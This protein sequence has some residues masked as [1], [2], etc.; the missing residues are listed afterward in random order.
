MTTIINNID[1][2][3]NLTDLDNTKNNYEK[4]LQDYNIKIQTKENE[5]TNLEK[6]VTIQQ[7][8]YWDVKN[9]SSY[10]KIAQAQ[11]SVTQKYLFWND[12]CCKNYTREKRKYNSNP[13]ELY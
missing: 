5:L 3:N 7:E 4:S 13:N 6:S 2:I 11:N 9:G 12:S 10:E 8:I 1:K